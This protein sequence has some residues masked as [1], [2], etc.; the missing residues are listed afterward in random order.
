M[1]QAMR[2]QEDVRND[3]RWQSVLA[4]DAARD[5]AFFYAVK[6]SGVYCRPSCP[7]RR[8]S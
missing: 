5:G 4:R 6:T 7:S 3:P 8:D 1:E 2:Q